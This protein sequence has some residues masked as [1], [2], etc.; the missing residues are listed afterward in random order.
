MSHL[1]SATEP[2]EAPSQVWPQLTTDLKRHAIR[3]LA[4]LAFDRVTAHTECCTPEEEVT[5]AV[6]TEYTQNHT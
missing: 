1:P 4:Q 5:H 6:D 3:L 2:R